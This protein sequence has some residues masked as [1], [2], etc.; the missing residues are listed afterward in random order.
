M[1]SEFHV[2]MAR[3]TW[4]GVRHAGVQKILMRTELGCRWGDHEVG[5]AL[6][7]DRWALLDRGQ[8][9]VAGVGDYLLADEVAHSRNCLGWGT[10]LLGGDDGAYRTRVR[11]LRAELGDPAYQGAS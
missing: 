8:E 4:D 5:S 2:D 6:P 9:R 11:E 7:R 3:Q 10:Y 1:P